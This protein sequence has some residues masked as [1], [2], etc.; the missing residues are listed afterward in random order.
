MSTLTKCE[1][2]T[3]RAL[4]LPSRRGMI[5]N[6]VNRH[7]SWEARCPTL[8]RPAIKMTYV[9]VSVRRMDIGV[10]HTQSESDRTDY[11]IDS[12]WRRKDSRIQYYITYD[13]H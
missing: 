4:P 12:L 9:S 6:L 3:W 13:Q 11:S 5:S 2:H 7:I 10:S 8:S 1:R